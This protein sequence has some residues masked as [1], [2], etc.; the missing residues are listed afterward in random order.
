V[1]HDAARPLVD[2][3]AFDRCALAA[4]EGGAAILAAPVVDTIKRVKSGQIV[5]TVPRDELWS[6]Q[7]PQAFRRDVLLRAL[8]SDIA[9][10]QVFTDE[11]GL[12]EALGLAVAI[13]PNEQPNL[14]ITRPA[15]L[16]LAEALLK[17]RMWGAESNAD[18]PDAVAVS[19]R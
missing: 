1:V 12:L 10:T 16:A 15:D 18:P 2:G 4:H 7:T 13:V 17:I 6:A 3:T 9:R 5:G 8:G 11:A 14:K 19:P